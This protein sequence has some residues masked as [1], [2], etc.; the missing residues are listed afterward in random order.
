MPKRVRLYIHA[1]L[2]VIALATTGRAPRIVMVGPRDLPTFEE[3]LTLR[4]SDG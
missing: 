4:D 3:R 1:C 2:T